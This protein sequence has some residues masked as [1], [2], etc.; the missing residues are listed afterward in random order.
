MV[1]ALA[2]VGN[3]AVSAAVV[4][5]R[6]LPSPPPATA[7]L[8]PLPGPVAV[9]PPPPARP[10]GVLSLRIGALGV[11]RPAIP[12]GLDRRGALQV[13]AQAAQLGYWRDGPLPGDPGAAVLVGHVDLD[14]EL[15][16]F[17][18]LAT[19]AVGDEVQAF[20]PDGRPVA[21]RVTRVQQ[22]A[23]A[24]FPTDDVYSPTAQ[25]ELRL[26]TCGGSFDRRSGHYRDNV[27]VYAVLA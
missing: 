10:R 21:F 9:D 22:V 19:L 26:V 8:S 5:V 15:G 16:V 3:L 20:R 25:P 12:L 23:K 17:A 11:D 1:L 18:R 24:A 4:V 14:G 6:S 7:A 2:L 27:V 13:P